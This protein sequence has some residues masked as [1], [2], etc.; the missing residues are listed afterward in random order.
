MN[1]YSFEK[2][3]DFFESSDY[4]KAIFKECDSSAPGLIFNDFVHEIGD[5]LELDIKYKSLNK[6]NTYWSLGENTDIQ[7][8]L[9]EDPQNNNGTFTIKS[10]NKLIEQQIQEHVVKYKHLM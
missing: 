6:E 1:E 2:K 8:L 7:L 3:Q 10:K 9:Q 5:D 4:A